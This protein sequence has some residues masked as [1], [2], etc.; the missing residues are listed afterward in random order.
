MMFAPISPSSRPCRNLRNR[1][2]DFIMAKTVLL[3]VNGRQVRTINPYQL[4]ISF[5]AENMY[6]EHQRIHFG[7]DVEHD[8]TEERLEK[9]AH[10]LARQAGLE[11]TYEVTAR[12]D[13]FD[14]DTEQWKSDFELYCWITLEDGEVIEGMSF[15][16]LNEARQAL[17]TEQ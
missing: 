12:F 15:V 8:F 1:K 13:K 7:V 14:F 10:V 3:S 17:Q 16:S 2:G 4:R 9:F 5:K 6:Q 11:G